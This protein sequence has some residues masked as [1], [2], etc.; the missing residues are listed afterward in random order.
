MG[1]DRDAQ[2]G[3]GRRGAAPPP[4]NGRLLVSLP[5]IDLGVGDKILGAK[6]PKFGVE[7]AFLVNF[8]DFSEKLYLKNAIKS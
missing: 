1:A 7:G 8:S 4:I 3:G 2:S 5:P 6:R